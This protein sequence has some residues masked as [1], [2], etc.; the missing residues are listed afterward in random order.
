[1]RNF[2]G[3]QIKKVNFIEF[4]AKINTLGS[5]NPVFPKY[6][7]TVLSSLLRDR[8]YDVR[9]YLEGV[10]DMDFEKMTDCDLVCFPVFAPATNKVRACA[11]RIMRERPGIPI[12]MGGPQVCYFPGSIADCCDFAVRCEG[13][14][15]LPEIINS[16]NEGGEPYRIDGITFMKDGKILHNREARPPVIPPTIPDL[17]LIVGYESATRGLV[18]R[19]R[20]T[21]TLQ[22]TRGCRYHCKFCPTMKLFQGVYRNRDIESVIQDIKKR[23]KISPIFFVVDNDFCSDKKKTRE[24][25]NRIIEEDLESRFTVFERHEIGRDGEMLDLFRRAGVGAIIVGVES[26]SDNSL[27][28]YNKKQTREQVMSAI[29]N[30]QLHGIHVLATFILGCDDDTPARAQEM[31]DFVISKKL[32]LNLFIMH[33]LEWEESENMLIPLN[34]RFQTYLERDHPGNTNFW[35]YATGSFVTYFPKRMKPSTLQKTVLNVYDQV[36]THRYILRNIFARNRVQAIFGV[37]LGYGIRSMNRSIR[38]V[39]EKYK[40]IEYLERIE[41]GLYDENEVLIEEKLADFSQKKFPP[42]TPLNE[43]PEGESYFI[44]RGLAIL[45]GLIRFALFI[46]R[47][48]LTRRKGW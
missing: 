10:S 17:S 22:T 25:L 36:Y 32:S 1:M 29:R 14:E 33:D 23:K 21:N 24:L 13:D 19:K 5:L 48:R 20:I 40:F 15:I 8:G 11:G 4:N 27:D 46:L 12:I 3:I 34:R 6:G 2:P 44:L 31:I 47:K 16:L 42:L 26:L 39:I 28:V 43:V 38:R 18:T 9:V 41:E 37:E 30:I 45:P 7:T 35:D